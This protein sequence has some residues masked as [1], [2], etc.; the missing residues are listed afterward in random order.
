MATTLGWRDE[1]DH[2]F[3]RDVQLLSGV[4]RMRADRAE[5]IVVRFGD[6]L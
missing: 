1:L 2:L 4:M 3:D 5:H 6:A